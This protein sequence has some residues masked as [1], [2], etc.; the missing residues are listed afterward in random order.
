M[1]SRMCFLGE[2]SGVLSPQKLLLL[3]MAVGLFC[4][5]VLRDSRELEE[6]SLLSPHYGVQQGLV[7]SDPVAMVTGQ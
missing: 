1:R 6:Q 4:S 2:V 3:S 7:N 5:G